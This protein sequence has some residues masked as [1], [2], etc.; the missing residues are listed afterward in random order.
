MDV[1]KQA[2]EHRDRIYVTNADSY[3]K[4][5]DEESELDSEW[6]DTTEYPT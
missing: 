2:L 3:I 6:A 1:W 5:E 4:I